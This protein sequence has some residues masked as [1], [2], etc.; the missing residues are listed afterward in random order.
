VRDETFAK[1]ASRSLWGHVVLAQLV[2]ALPL[3]FFFMWARFDGS[4]R[5]LLI[6]TAICVL[7][8]VCFAVILWYTMSAPLIRRMRNR[9]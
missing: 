3:W 6:L 8:G 1:W 2:F 9:E 7:G 4:V 5:V